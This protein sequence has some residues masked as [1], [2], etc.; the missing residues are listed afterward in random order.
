MSSSCYLRPDSPVGLIGISS[1]EKS[2]SSH[3]TS[4][5]LESSVR[6]KLF[7]LI[8]IVRVHGSPPCQRIAAQDSLDNDN[9]HTQ[10]HQVTQKEEY[11]VTSRNPD[12]GVVK[13]RDNNEQENHDGR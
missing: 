12:I 8:P 6:L 4:G 11:D 10:Q 13:R 7:G 2:G 5:A 3:I 9:E 1:R